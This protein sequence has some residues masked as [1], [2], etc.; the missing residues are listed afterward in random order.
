MAQWENA[1]AN[2]FD[3]PNSMSGSHVGDREPTHMHCGMCMPPNR[4]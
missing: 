2:K 1:L 4:K 3:A